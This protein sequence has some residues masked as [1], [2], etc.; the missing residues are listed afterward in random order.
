[1]SHHSD[2]RLGLLSARLL[3]WSD[4]LL[5]PILALVAVQPL[6]GHALPQ[7]A[8]GLLHFYRLAQL[9]H[10][11]RHG[12]LFP[13]WMPDMGYGYGFPLFNYYPPLS[14][15][16]A[17]A[18]HLIGLSTQGALQAAFALAIVVGCMGVYLWGH[19][20][21]GRPAGLVAA[22]AFAYAPY[23]L[24]NVIHRGA[25]AE[26]WGV[27]WIPFVL[28]G[29]R[30]V[31]L[32]TPPAPSPLPKWGEERG[33][34][35]EVRDYQAPSLLALLY[36]ALLLTHNVLT[37]IATPLFVAYAA[38][39]WV[40][41]G[42]GLRRALRLG[43]MLVLGLGLAAFFWAPAFFEREYVQISQVYT[44]ADADYH[45]NF[46]TLSELLSPPQSV[47][48]ALIHP[49]I[50][51]SL[52][53]PQLALALIAFIG[54]RRLA[55][56]ETRV[57][58]GLAGMGLL[59]FT[60]LMLPCAVGAWEH[61]PLLHFVQL[62]W[63]F[64]GPASLLLAVLASAGVTRL[65]VPNW[66]RLPIA[67][68]P[69]ITFAFTWLFP[70]FYPPQTQ[71]TPL[72]LIAFERD[73]G[74]LGTTSWGEYLPVWVQQLPAADS[75]VP[76]YQAAGPDGIIPRLI[77]ESLPP[78]A[79][80]A[81]ARYHLTSADLIIETPAEF[82][83]IF[84]WYYFP[85][86][87]GQL[88]G[89]PLALRPTGEH[90]LIGAVVPA[91]R[92]HLTVRFGDTPLRR[93][94]TIVSGLSLIALLSVLLAARLSPIA[95]RN[96]A[97][98]QSPTLHSLIPNPLLPT[99]L[100]V[101]VLFVFKSAY[102]DHRD[103]IFR[104]SRFDG[105][106][107]I[108]VQVPLRVN[109]DDQLMLLGYDLDAT[110]VRGDGV[111]DVTL[112]WQLLRPLDVDYSVALHLVDERGIL[113]GQ[114]DNQHPANYPTSRWE[115]GTYARDLHRLTIRPDTP[116]GIYQLVTSVYDVRTGHGLDILDVAG[117]PAGTFYRLGSVQ[118]TQPTRRAS[119]DEI[120]TAY[121]LDADLGALTLVGVDLNRA[122]AAPGDPLL[123]T[124][125]WLAEETPMQDLA[126]RL[127]LIA[128]DGSIAAT[129][130]L[131]PTSAAHPTTTWRA[132]DFWRGQHL[133]TLPAYLKSGDYTWQLA[134]TPTN[135]PTNQPTSQP[136]VH[137][138]TFL[139]ITAPPHTFT[140]PSFQHPVGITLGHQATL[141]GYDLSADTLTAG[142]SFTI[143]LYWRAE[144]TAPTGYIV[145]VHLL[146]PANR[147]YAQSDRP[148]A[149]G[150]R[151]TTGW[152]PGEIIRDEHV[153]TIDANA[154]PGRYV[155][156]VGLYDP[157][158]GERLRSTEAQDHIL[159]P[160]QV[161]VK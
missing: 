81:E 141:L 37:L 69:V 44:P 20:L 131:P 93:G 142:Q 17:E 92:H 129:F 55:G 34:G 137:F 32:T 24:F 111:L 21:F 22:A 12:V 140:P 114:R 153:L 4:G 66:L 113:Y 150:T 143:T 138:S 157:T 30:R 52:G 14:Y 7:S 99:S 73:T 75:L 82:T 26:A 3:R 9:D 136:T 50:P 13:R 101:L 84:A 154:A 105:Q 94:A 149:A 122:E 2:G 88:D 147:I 121:R 74:A 148:P 160:T 127:A 71:P 106:R 23:T 16:I 133:L 95:Y 60:V 31:A 77:P 58:L 5:L 42:R 90:G 146:D 124:F 125:Y 135:Q 116:P 107:V 117:A 79:Q 102:L 100:L 41:H 130:D 10:A 128:A 46:I 65:P 18:F 80:V 45:N 11:L 152:L 78:G 54:L 126:A 103:S 57:H 59:I 33:G 156:H 144:A 6:L 70:R 161:Q 123:V 40:L 159:L 1:M 139:H 115:M 38:I 53:W 29:L 49:P 28:W 145:F 134:L 91:G 35:G 97:N 119:H 89:Q 83:A 61:L 158:S 36:A 67:L 112:Y 104:A 120:E 108:G 39:L 87:Q 63:R 47:D 25:L 72:S 27:A 64:L 118:V 43:G 109:F 15:Y 86:W 151:P 8:D 110:Q 51:R 85:G 98:R 68:V 132:G 62:P 48:P 155:L 76:V 56:R 96:S 19:D